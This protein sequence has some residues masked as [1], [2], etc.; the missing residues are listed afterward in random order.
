MPSHDFDYDLVVR[1]A[2]LAG[3]AEVFEACGR[4]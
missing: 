2:T 3:P 1:G 4:V